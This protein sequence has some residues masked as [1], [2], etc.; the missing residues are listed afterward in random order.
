MAEIPLNQFAVTMSTVPL[1]LSFDHTN[2]L[3][4]S[5]LFPINFQGKCEKKNFSDWKVKGVPTEVLAREY[6]RR[7]GVEHYWDLALSET[8]VEQEQDD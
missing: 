4:F 7:Y 2:L 8:I 3:T 6:L 5:S 1:A